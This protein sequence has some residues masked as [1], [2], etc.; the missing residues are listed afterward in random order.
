MLIKQESLAEYKINTQEEK[1]IFNFLVNGN[2]DIFYYINKED[3]NVTYLACLKKDSL[4]LLI[5]YPY[6]EMYFC[7][8]VSSNGQIIRSNS[9]YINVF[10]KYIFEKEK[11]L[12]IDQLKDI[13]KEDYSYLLEL[14]S[15]NKKD[16][17]AYQNFKNKL[18]SLI[19]EME[20]NL[21]YLNT[22]NNELSKPMLLELILD[23]DKKEYY[24]DDY[25]NIDYKIKA[26]ASKSLIIKNKE[27]FLNCYIQ[28]SIYDNESYK[29][30]FYNQK[31]L[32]NTKKTLKI[33]AYTLLDDFNNCSLYK[34]QLLRVILANRL[35]Y[36]Y[37]QNDKTSYFINQEI[38]NGYISFDKDEN[39]VIYPNI[40][41]D[42]DYLIIVEDFL[43]L[44]SKINDKRQ[45]NLYKFASDDIS[46]L[47]SFL[48]ENRKIDLNPVKD[49]IRNRII[50]NEKL[51]LL[52]KV[53]LND[54]KDNENIHFNITL[55]VSMDNNEYLHFQT[56]YTLNNNI[57]DKKE[58]LNNAYYKM[59]Y[60]SYLE[61]LTPLKG[62]ENGI[63]T[64]KENI[65][66]F[67]HSD[68]SKLKQFITLVF[69]NELN[70]LY[71]LSSSDLSI[72]LSYKND[73][74]SANLL[75]SN[76]TKEQLEEIL[77]NIKDGKDYFILANK[78]ILI[79][80]EKIQEQLKVIDELKINPNT[81]ENNKVPFFEALKLEA[82]NNSTLSLQ[83]DDYIKQAITSISN[84]KEESVNFPNKINS[85]I[86]DYQIDAV[87]WMLTLTKNHLCGI[88]ADDMGL[89]KTLETI[90][91]ISNL[92]Y[93]LPILIVSPKSLIYNWQKEFDKWLTEMKTVVID[94]DKN[95]RINDIN[96]ID[97][98]KKEVFITSYDSL[99]SDL[100]NYEQKKFSLIVLDEAQYIK[101][102]K[103]L[104][105]KAVKQLD[106][107]IRFAL[108]GTPIENDIV[109]LWSIF[110]FL[111]PS[112]LYDENHFIKTYNT[113][114]SDN[115]QSLI[116]KITPFI[117]R[118]SK[119][120]V[121]T[122]LPE[123]TEEILTV[124]MDDKQQ[125]LY[126]SYLLQ[127]Q[128]QLK[129]NDNRLSIL[130]NILR[131]REICVDPSMVI[132]NLDFL[133]VKLTMTLQIISESI[134]N[135]HKILV[136]S[137]FTMVLSH[138][139]KLLEESNI[140]SYY[141]YGEIKAKDRILLADKFNINNDVKVMLVSLKAGGTGLNLV[142]ADTVIHLDPWWNPAVEN[143][144][145][146]RVHRIGQ[147]NPVTVYKLIC[148]NTIEEKVIQLQQQKEKLYS[149][150]IK[151]GDVNISN[152]SLDDLKYILS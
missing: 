68:F 139:Q 121:L 85:A 15:L 49:L 78:V 79:D 65:S 118:R 94:G 9:K 3:G 35:S 51:N 113:S 132:D 38:K 91:F 109:D 90:A 145:T 112:Y 36:I 106:S 144:A 101:N 149:T 48:L 147:V 32:D 117:L 142:G 80:R 127:T 110:D 21:N 134:A 53:D 16:Y 8:V 77:K 1:D 58:L 69:S 128:E 86:R 46:K 82:F 81:L 103:A 74:L 47:Y 72:S 131:L 116:K 23:L 12:T 29:I 96:S 27:D 141:I 22:N 89:G 138:L 31:M 99:R 64:S 124:N 75:S 25:S 52:K 143:Q 88:L 123:K 41:D 70:N 57:I 152:F 26:G 18:N 130:T 19:N 14:D 61:L 62:I 20:T 67:L 60:N 54:L 34:Y 115:E 133:S 146:S 84:F 10:L 5:N 11:D 119:K 73:W 28:K 66:F 140:P 136:F 107:K 129:T 42:Y 30:D 126:S 63:I 17:Q 111:M 122:S 151:D 93:E 7:I 56:T 24:F 37:V 50:N 55:F 33:L 39:L 120:D 135:G 137:S 104:K 44:F 100:E 98:S 13:Y 97:N 43:I 87:K 114:N 83:F 45:V 95:S 2:Y 125:A 40:V 108:T 92:K 76:F 71:Q 105:S 6:L 59:L 148:H 150:Y 102:S 4:K